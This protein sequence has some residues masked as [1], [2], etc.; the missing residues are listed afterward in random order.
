MK[1]LHTPK[2]VGGGEDVY[3]YINK[4]SC[5]LCCSFITDGCG[6]LS[7]SPEYLT[8]VFSLE[9]LEYPPESAVPWWPL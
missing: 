4:K 3:K 2:G 9:G 5:A 7:Q 8:Q 1:Q 6:I